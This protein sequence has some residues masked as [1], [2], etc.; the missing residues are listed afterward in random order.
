MDSLFTEI[1]R[2]ILTTSGLSGAIILLLLFVIGYQYI[3]RQK[4]GK[5]WDAERQELNN[6]LLGYVKDYM[7]ALHASSTTVTALTVSLEARN[8]ALDKIADVIKEMS[9]TQEANRDK[10]SDLGRRLEDGIKDILNAQRG[11]GHP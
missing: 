6:Q 5:A 8:A 4:D 3:E 10:F 9:Q 7:T 11:G 1:V 2:A